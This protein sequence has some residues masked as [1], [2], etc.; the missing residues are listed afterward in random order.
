M[1]KTPNQLNCRVV[2]VGGS[3]ESLADLPERI[4]SW[5]KPHSARH[6]LL[7]AGGGRRADR[8]RRRDEQTGLARDTAHW[9]AIRAMARNT[10]HLARKFPQAALVTS[11]ADC[12][13]QSSGPAPK[14]WF[15]DVWRWLRE[16]EP[17]A[18]GTPLPCGW[19]VTSD[20]IA[21]RLAEVVGADELTLLKSTSLPNGAH[22]LS[23]QA[24]IDCQLVDEHFSFAARS[25]PKIR[26][27]NLRDPESWRDE[28]CLRR[29]RD[30]A[31]P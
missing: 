7:I 15:V 22:E 5:L 14:L 19:H 27:V 4:A 25:I 12:L 3:L 20:S 17:A 28:F 26:V 16:L 10:C 21:A 1:N 18:P 24:A 13:R 23:L 9:L 8:V 31:P 6:H 2:K 30:D 29:S 11:P